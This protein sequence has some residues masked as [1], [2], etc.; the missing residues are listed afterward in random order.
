MT[1]RTGARQSS[2]EI[3]PD[4]ELTQ[5]F[6]F[7]S[8]LDLMLAQIY[9]FDPDSLE[10]TYLNRSALDRLGWEVSDIAGKTLVDVARKMS[11]CEIRA[12]I[13]D[14]VEGREREKTVEIIADDGT[15]FEIIGQLL[16]LPDGARRIV[17]VIRDISA[18]KAAER[19]M[20]NFRTL[21]ARAKDPILIFRTDDLRL[22]YLN[23]AAIRQFG[24]Q[25]VRWQ[26]KTVADVSGFFD[27]EQFRMRTRPLLAGRCDSVRFEAEDLN[28]I[29]Y[30][31]VL[32][33]I[34]A[35][36]NELRFMAVS[37]DI[38]DRREI[39]KRKN[40]FLSTVTHE[41]RTP[42]T[43]IKGALDLIESGT[44]GR[45]DDTFRPM[46]E[47]ARKSSDRLMA[48]INDI[49]DIQR[50]ESGNTPF[51]FMSVDIG[52]LVVDSVETMRAQAD[53]ADVSLCL[54]KIPE[55][56]MAIVDPGRLN[57]VMEKLLSNAIAF[58]EKG[59]RIDVSATC[60]DDD[61]T[62]AIRDFG[63]GIPQE[64]LDCI[65]D[66][67]TQADASDTRQKGGTGLGLAIARRIIE[68][69][70]GTLKAESRPGEGATFRF[71][72]PLA[73]EGDQDDT[74][75]SDV[76]SHGDHL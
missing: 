51:D 76:P 44:L 70:G 29:P 36:S 20:E 6:E 7:R 75:G 28:G 33:V 68:S 55:G 12:H 45:V 63:A 66:S 17:A 69:H 67:F 25:N 57:Q 32:Q 40:A 65:F 37:R 47:L 22:T 30:E 10:I 34:R 41:L 42:L 9:V 54:G 11:E 23:D 15:P 3:S 16:D 74:G 49:L 14:L 43:T 58:S 52:Q 62:V 13:R 27:P 35:E 19:E 61:L 39:E 46:L 24:W 1:D 71:T 31:T 2:R 60:H 38:S 59:G 50:F 53:R 56:C 8:A 73:R 5:N 48:L 64:A 4:D 18:R 21:L 72:L 26:D